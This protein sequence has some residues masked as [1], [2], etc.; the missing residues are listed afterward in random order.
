[1]RTLLI[2]LRPAAIAEA[3]LV[4]LMRQLAESTTGR[5]RIPV[6]LQ[7]DGECD[8]TPEAKIVLY[9]IAQEALNNVAK[10]AKATRAAIRLVC[11]E[12]KV[13]LTIEDDG[14][15]FDTGSVPPDHL[16]LE[17]MRERAESIGAELAI[18]SGQNKGARITLTWMW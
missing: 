18:E 4:E 3:D 11:E 8:F 1:M 12:Q 6:D 10:H 2:E 15:G 17:I 7:V 5:A 16:G 14:V 13:E 9:R